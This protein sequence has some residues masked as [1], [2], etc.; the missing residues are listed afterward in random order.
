[1][2]AVIQLNNNFYTERHLNMKQHMGDDE[3]A[4][5]TPLKNPC[6]SEGRDFTLVY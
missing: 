6:R 1:M 4:N 3:P 2:L 5:K